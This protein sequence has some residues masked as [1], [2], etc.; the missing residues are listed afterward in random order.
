MAVFLGMFL[1]LAETV[2]RIH[3]ILAFQNFFRWFD[4]YLLGSILLLAS[5]TVYKQKQN[6]ILYLI[7]AWGAA[8]GALAG[9]LCG[10]FDGYFKNLADAG[11]FS[12]GFVLVAKAL[13]L[14]YIL[15]GLQQSIKATQLN[16]GK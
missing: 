9:S 8:A 11:V 7:A 13:F 12:S 14:L 2:R 5:Y 3:E 10:Q 1:P 6:S 16:S 4:D 15:I